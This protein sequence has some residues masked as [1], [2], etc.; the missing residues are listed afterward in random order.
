MYN[1]TNSKEPLFVCL[2]ASELVHVPE[3]L[4]EIHCLFFVSLILDKANN[5]SSEEVAMY[6]RVN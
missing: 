5:L 1:I 6:V 4:S 3:D 2:E